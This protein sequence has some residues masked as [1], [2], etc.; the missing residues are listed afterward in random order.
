M[1]SILAPMNIYLLGNTILEFK[2]LASTNDYALELAKKN[3]KLL[4]NGLVVWTRN[5]T[6]GRGQREN[7]WISEK[8]SNLTFSIVLNQLQLA[9]SNS[10]YLSMAIA[11]GVTNYLTE[12][13]IIV[14]IKWPNDILVNK[15]KMAGI[16]IENSLKGN[17]IN[18]SIVGVGININ[19]QKFDNLN[20]TSLFNE[21]NIVYDLK[22]ELLKI[23]KCIEK[24]FVRLSLKKYDLITN[25]Y[26]QNLFGYKTILNYKTNTEVFEAKI[27]DIKSD[28]AIELELNDKSRREYYFKEVLFEL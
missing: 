13:N 21:T 20:A 19:Q 14:Q 7:S 10:F 22:P 3:D 18:Q 12:N 16:L 8:D 17:L 28:G 26:L 2:E 5:Q 24:Q 11:L 15:Q 9:V 25:E 27:I 6:N 23:I 4:E 1:S